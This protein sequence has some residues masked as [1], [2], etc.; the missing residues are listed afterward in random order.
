M[1]HNYLQ[2]ILLWANSPRFQ[3][4][5]GFVVSRRFAKNCKDGALNRLWSIKGGATGYS[6]SPVP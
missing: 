4:L 1:E 5:G 3:W 6:L 2:K